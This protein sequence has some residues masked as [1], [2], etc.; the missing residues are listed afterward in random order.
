MRFS[1]ICLISV[2]TKGASVDQQD[3]LSRENSSGSVSADKTGLTLV[4]ADGKCTMR[5]R[6]HRSNG[7]FEDN[8]PRPE[9]KE[10]ANCLDPPAEP[11]ANNLMS[12]FITIFIHPDPQ[13]TQVICKEINNPQEEIARYTYTHPPM[14]KRFLSLFSGKPDERDYCDALENVRVRLQAY[15]DQ[16]ASPAAVNIAA[17]KRFVDYVPSENEPTKVYKTGAVIANNGSCITQFTEDYDD[18][19]GSETQGRIENKVTENSGSLSTCLNVDKTVQPVKEKFTPI[20][21]S[22]IYEN[23]DKVPFLSCYTRKNNQPEYMFAIYQAPD[24]TLS[25]L[26]AKS[27]DEICKSLKDR[28]TFLHRTV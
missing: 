8:A 24:V 18:Q 27:R 20:Y 23:R 10:S 26:S 19:T 9:I 1:Q 5:V 3:S 4:S 11:K 6:M 13:T 14:K 21:V 28:W 12:R 16:V 15:N 2:V 25:E 7:L 17:I 22:Q